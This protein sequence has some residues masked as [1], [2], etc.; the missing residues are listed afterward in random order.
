MTEAN[1]TV[2]LRVNGTDYGGWKEVEITA[3]I[4]RQVRD[5]SLAV[6]DRWPGQT[7]VP[8]R[9]R[10]GDVCEVFIGSDL[11]L[12]GYVD[13]TPIRYDGRQVS[14]GVKGRSKTQDLVDCAAINK[15]GSWSGATVER[16]AR[17]LASTYGIKVT[18]EVTAGAPLSHSIEQGETVFESIDRLLRLRQLLA[19]DDAEG[20]LVFISV[21]SAGTAATALRHGDNILAADTG[22]DYKEVFSEYICKGQRAGNDQD[23]GAAVSEETASITDS[24]VRRRRVMLI[25]ASGQTDGGSAADRVKYERASRRGKAL[26]TT[27]TVAGWRQANG[28]L[29]RHN[30]LVRVTDPVIG[31]D[32]QFVVAQV[33]YRLNDKG[34]VCMLQVGPPDGYVN[35]PAK[36]KAKKDATDKKIAEWGDV[37]PADSKAPKV[38]NKPVNSKEGWS[39]VKRVR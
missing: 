33:T 1:N 34:M 22:L 26:S 19:T 12:T 21:G 36:G 23:F 25:K 17:D 18:S 2:R 13:G 29:W 5:F 16:I 9:I 6:T 20:R 39:D 31:F 11:V 10:P 30:Q 7:D 35:N 38:N 8:R 3:G 37:R 28:S 4:E 15:P 27:Y 32:D 24:T 14:V